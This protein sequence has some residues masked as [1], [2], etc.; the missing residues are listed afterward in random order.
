MRQALYENGFPVPRPIDQARHTVVMSLIDAFP[1]RQIRSLSDPGLLYSR[2][3]DLIVRLAKVGL[4]HGDF[5]EFNILVKEPLDDDGE[6]VEGADVEPILIDF[7][8]MV[9]VD[10]PNAELSTPPSPSSAP[11]DPHPLQLL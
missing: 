3:M 7:P 2:L 9:S 11:T 6:P 10:H 5:N 4:I 8:Q 1:L